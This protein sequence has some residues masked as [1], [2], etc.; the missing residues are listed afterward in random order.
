M[1][2]K[3][4]S[5]GVSAHL[6]IGGTFRSDITAPIWTDSIHNTSTAL[7]PPSEAQNHQGVIISF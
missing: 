5:M 2:W 4:G 1:R 6:V 7:R 3:V